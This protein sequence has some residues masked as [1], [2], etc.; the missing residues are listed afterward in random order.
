MFDNDEAWDE[1]GHFTDVFVQTNS[2]NATTAKVLKRKLIE[3][4]RESDRIQPGT[5]KAVLFENAKST[6]GTVSSRVFNAAYK[7]V[8]GKSVGRPRK[9]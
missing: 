8:F 1:F 2:N 6:L 9:K 4:L 3:F 5:K 7:D